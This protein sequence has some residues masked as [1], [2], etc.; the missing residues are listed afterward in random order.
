M[1]PGGMNPCRPFILQ[2]GGDAAAGA[3][4]PDLRRRRL[5]HAAGRRLA[6]RRISGDQRLAALPGASAEIMATAVAAPLERQLAYLDGLESMKLELVEGQHL[7]HAAAST[8][9]ATSTLPAIDVQSAINERRR[10]FADATC[11]TRPAIS[12]RIRPTAI[13]VMAF[14][15][16]V[17][18]LTKVDRCRHLVVRRIRNLPASRAPSSPTSRNTRSASRSIRSLAAR[19]LSPEDVRTRSSAPRSTGPRAG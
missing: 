13:V 18:P 10:R 6:R 1:T 17:M 9:A 16:D 15:S 3:R 11:R 4:R 19:G 12:R 14:T 8:S 2:A 5:G 7:H